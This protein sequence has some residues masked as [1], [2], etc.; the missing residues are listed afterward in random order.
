MSAT[1]S[2]KAKIARRVV[3]VLEFFDEDHPHAT[4]MDIVRRYNRPQSSTSE[5]L[6]SLVGLGLLYKDPVTRSFTPTPRAALLGSSVQSGVVRDG[7]LAGLIDRLSAQTG[8]GIAVFGMVGTTAQIFNWRPGKWQLRTSQTD[9]LAGGQHEVLTETAAGHLL[10]STLPQA[11]RDGLLRRINAEAPAERKFV[12][13]E[14]VARIQACADSGYAAGVA[15]FGSIADVAAML[16]PDQPAG[17][18]LAIGLVYEPSEQI[19][20]DM[21]RTTLAEAIARCT[22]EAPSPAAEVE[23]IAGVA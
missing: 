16:L 18:P 6:S 13:G 5:L 3:E 10:L 12:F 17:R 2:N 11:R 19:N 14:M 8:L 4:V 1:E 9:G 22:S 7:R 23:R 20:A 15:G 21:L